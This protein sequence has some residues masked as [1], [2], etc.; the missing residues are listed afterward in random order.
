M[1]FILFRMEIF[2]Y[3]GDHPS[4]TQA[5]QAAYDEETLV[6]WFGWFGDGMDGRIP[7]LHI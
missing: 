4:F 5:P 2:A 7:N 3:L 1:K 6:G